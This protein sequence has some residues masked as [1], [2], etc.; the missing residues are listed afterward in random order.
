MKLKELKNLKNVLLTY[1]VFSS[2]YE[3]QKTKNIRYIDYCKE[4]FGID[5]K[6]KTEMGG[7]KS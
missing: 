7:G 4:V 2:G 6:Y 3:L 1:S 5:P